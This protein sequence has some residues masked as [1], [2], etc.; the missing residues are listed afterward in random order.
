[1]QFNSSSPLSGAKG[2]EYSTRCT[3]CHGEWNSLAPERDRV[4]LERDVWNRDGSG[5]GLF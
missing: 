3:T 4:R 1:M 2:N 5:E